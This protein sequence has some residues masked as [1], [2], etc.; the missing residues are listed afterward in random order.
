[1][2]VSYALVSADGIEFLVGTL[3]GLYVR[4]RALGYR[5]RRYELDP[6]CESFDPARRQRYLE[7]TRVRVLT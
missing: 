3:T 5:G 2:D 7:D 6:D 1:M 4:P